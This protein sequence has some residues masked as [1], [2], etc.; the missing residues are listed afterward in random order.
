MFQRLFV[1]AFA[2]LFMFL[3]ATTV[4]AA[5]DDE[6]LNFIRDLAQKAI[7]TVATQ[8]ITDNDRNQRFRQLFVSAFDIPEIGKFVLS[9][10]WQS[11]TPTQQAE[12]LKLFEDTQ[13]LIWSQRFKRYNGV[14][15]DTKGVKVENETT[16]LVDSQ[17]IRPQGPPT[18][19]QWRV[20]K[21]VGGSLRIIDIIA[22]GVSM[23]LTYRGDYAAVLQSNGGNVDALLSTMRAKN[24]SLSKA[25]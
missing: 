14:R 11:A 13:V 23:A 16:W 3:G 12:F 17:I 25:P 20:Q 8:D 24:I 2:A 10:H 7:T 9:R 6:A 1:P 18:Q 5:A 15:L 21:A 22:E 19:V 4:R